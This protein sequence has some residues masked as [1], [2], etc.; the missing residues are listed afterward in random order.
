MTV[1]LNHQNFEKETIQEYLHIDKH[2]N[3]LVT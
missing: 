1:T 3:Q 2:Q